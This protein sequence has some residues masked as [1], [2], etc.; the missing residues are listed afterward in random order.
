MIGLIAKMSQ[1]ASHILHHISTIQPR[2][3]EVEISFWE[4]LFVCWDEDHFGVEVRTDGVVFVEIGPCRT[5]H[6]E[7]AV[8]SLVVFGHA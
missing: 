2:V 4:H 6:D 3:S 5:R 8:A 1:P 7:N